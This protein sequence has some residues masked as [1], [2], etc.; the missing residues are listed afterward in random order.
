MEWKITKSIIEIVVTL[1]FASSFLF[2]QTI[3][4]NA[5]PNQI[6]N[7]EKTHSAHLKGSISSAKVLKVEWTCPQNNKV[8][9]K[10]ASTL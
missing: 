4:I 9:F 8:V 7:W 6:I 2:S 3:L 5:G 10:N 1:L